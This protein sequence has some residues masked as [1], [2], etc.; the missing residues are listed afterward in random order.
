MKKVWP[1]EGKGILPGESVNWGTFR[2]TAQFSELSIHQA[3]YGL[4]PFLVTAPTMTYAFQKSV[5]KLRALYGSAYN[6]KP[7]QKSQWV[8]VPPLW[9]DS[10]HLSVIIKYFLTMQSYPK[11]NHSLSQISALFSLPWYGC[12][13]HS[14]EG[15][16]SEISFA[17]NHWVSD[18]PCLLLLPPQGCPDQ[19]RVRWH[20][21]SLSPESFS[22]S[23]FFL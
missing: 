14:L 11:L 20:V 4:V 18:L 13:G 3:A 17:E 5:P 2:S 15:I 22:A 8:Y 16:W 6:T 21:H 23:S 10:I 12:T 19:A 9:E 1:R 7:S